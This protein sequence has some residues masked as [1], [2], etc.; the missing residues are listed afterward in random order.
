MAHTP[1]S[2]SPAARQLERTLPRGTVARGSAA[3]ARL[4]ELW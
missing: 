1:T 4:R 3:E 2:S